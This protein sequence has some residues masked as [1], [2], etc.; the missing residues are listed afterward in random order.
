MITGLLIAL[1]IIAAGYTFLFLRDYW[2]NRLQNQGKNWLP[3]LGIGFGTNFFDTL[4]IGSFAT[5]TALFKFFH[6]VDDKEIPGTLNAGHALP[7]VTQAFIFIAVVDV[8]PITL[9][10]MIGAAVAGAVIGAGIV[11]K[12]PERKIQFGMGFA[13]ALVALVLLSS[14]LGL[15]PLGGTAI[16]LEGFKLA[17][18]LGVSFIL[19]AI[20][21]IGVGLYAPCMAL[22]YSLGMSPLAAFPIM[23]GSCAFLMSTASIKFIDKAAY[24]RK[25]ALALTLGGIPGVLIAGLIVRSLPLVA[26]KWLILV[27]ICYTSFSMF[28][29]AIH[30]ISS[31]DQKTPTPENTMS[32]AQDTIEN[33]KDIATGM[34]T[35]PTSVDEMPP[36]ALS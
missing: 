34:N 24:N 14:L 6:S 1:G 18:A 7:I 35:T 21:M 5:T 2:K 27:A 9:I 20:M 15:F 8:E 3:L 30:R 36:P 17:F 23:M 10:S 28:R 26:L 31:L 22:V 25:A 13:L 33:A 4:G 19:G 11:V 29:S 32:P 12:L 16:G